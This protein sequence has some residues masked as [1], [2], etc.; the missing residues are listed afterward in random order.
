MNQVLT[1]TIVSILFTIANDAQA[2]Q[3]PSALEEAQQH[4]DVNLPSLRKFQRRSKSNH[5]YRPAWVTEAAVSGTLNSVDVADLQIG[6]VGSEAIKNAQTPT[7]PSPKSFQ[8][9]QKEQRQSKW[10]PKAKRIKQ[11]GGFTLTPSASA[12]KRIPTSISVDTKSVR[13]RGNKKIYLK[14][15]DVAVSEPSQAAK[16][17]PLA[18]LASI[19]TLP[20]PSQVK[21]VV[22]ASEVKSVVK[23]EYPFASLFAEVHEQ[24]IT[25]GVKAIAGEQQ[26]ASAPARAP[27]ANRRF[28]MKRRKR[29][30]GKGSNR[31]TNDTPKTEPNTGSSF[32]QLCFIPLLG[33]LGWMAWKLPGEERFYV[34]GESS[35]TVTESELLDEVNLIRAIRL[36]SAL[37]QHSTSNLGVELEEGGR[38]TREPVDENVFGRQRQET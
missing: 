29:I 31:Q 10:K 19:T 36:S 13:A 30:A 15:T 26:L 2:V 7:L 28:A 1:I 6:A 24:P 21:L 35:Q 23:E 16:L 34:E 18:A 37:R 3:Q 20:P 27:S 11:G 22:A 8:Y 25:A 17:T 4:A 12:A 32:L 33:W 14:S 38:K 9:M 5:N